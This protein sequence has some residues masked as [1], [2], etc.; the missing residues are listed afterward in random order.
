MAYDLSSYGY[1][2]LDIGHIDV[3]YECFLQKATEKQPIKNKYVGEVNNGAN[4]NT[5]S[6]LKYESEIIARII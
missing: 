5:I 4:V 2:I 1:Q 3:E 6:D